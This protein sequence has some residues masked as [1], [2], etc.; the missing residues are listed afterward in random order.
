MDVAMRPKKRQPT[1]DGIMKTAK[2]AFVM[3]VYFF[4]EEGILHITWIV[5]WRLCDGKVFFEEIAVSEKEFNEF[6]EAAKKNW[7]T[8]LTELMDDEYEAS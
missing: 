1:F 6:K 3:P 7:G 8:H 5:N 4:V 2:D